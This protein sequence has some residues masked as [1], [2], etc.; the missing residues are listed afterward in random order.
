MKVPMLK[1]ALRI[2]RHG[3]RTGQAL[4]EFAIILPILA[5]LL[6]GAIDLSRVYQASLTLQ[7]A[8]RNAAESAASSALDS[9]SALTTARGIVCNETQHLPGFVPGPGGAIATCTAPTVTITSFSRSST[10]PGAS[11]RYPIAS[12][13]V[14]T[15][16]A[17]E[18][19]FRWPLLPEG[20]W[21]LDST[22]SYSV[23]QNR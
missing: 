9:A 16:L 15:S 6:G 3:S 1:A 11:V 17:F 4:V 22:Q 21:T 10:V 14:H 19:L 13:T 12:V 18:M 7:S 23:V 8:T 5:A 20:G 2:R